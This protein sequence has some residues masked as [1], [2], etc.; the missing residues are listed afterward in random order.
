[1]I[2]VDKKEHYYWSDIDSIT[3]NL[4]EKILELYI[5]PIY[6][7]GIPRGG[8][9]PAVILSHKTGI[10]YQQISSVGTYV[11]SNFSHV[12]FVDDICD[13]GNTLEKIKKTYNECRIITL[14]T[15]ES[16][17]T[18]PDIYWRTTE[19]EWATFPWESHGSLEKRD[20]TEI[21]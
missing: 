9:V 8:L 10:P 17:S 20:N 4:A 3:N 21:E 13:S 14:L 11:K 6:I 7:C 5:K 12:L 19:C 18:Q 16:A 15:K 2:E 1:M